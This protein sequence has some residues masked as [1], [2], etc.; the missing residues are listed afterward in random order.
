MNSTEWMEVVKFYGILATAITAILGVS[1]QWSSAYKARP[2]QNTVPDAVSHAMASN[3]E[4]DS[5]ARRELM[6]ALGEVNLRLADN[7][8]KVIETGQGHRQ[9]TE[10]LHEKTRSHIDGMKTEFKSDLNDIKKNQMT[11]NQTV[12]KFG[13]I[14]TQRAA[15]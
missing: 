11:I 12:E 2:A 4:K 14:L 8:T 6:Q 3:I 9:R 13:N 10:E 5:G 15:A 7:M 1:W